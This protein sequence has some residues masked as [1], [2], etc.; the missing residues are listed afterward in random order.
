[1]KEVKFQRKE[2]DKNLQRIYDFHLESVKR[3]RFNPGR[4]AHG[5]LIQSEN[6]SGTSL[7]VMS[8]GSKENVHK[9]KRQGR[10]FRFSQDF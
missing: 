6:L 4:D 7:S 8:V 2:N 9:N 10:C 1:M 5:Y 3:S